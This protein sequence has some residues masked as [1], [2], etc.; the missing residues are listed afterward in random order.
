V[1][2]PRATT[3]RATP[4]ELPF[5]ARFTAR[6]RELAEQ[7]AG[8]VRELRRAAAARFDARGLPHSRIEQW[9]STNL[10]PLYATE[11]HPV[12]PEGEDASVELRASDRV[13]VGTLERAL[14]TIPE[15]L[16]PHLDRL[17]RE[18]ETAFAALNGA[19]LDAGAVVVIPEGLELDEPI[20]VQHTTSA[21]ARATASHPR[22]LVVAGR[23]SRARLVETYTGRADAVYFTNAVTEVIVADGAQLDH[24]RIQLESA[25]AFH[26]STTSSRQGRDSRYTTQAVDLGGRL[27]R[28]DVVARLDGPGA[29]CR[30]DGLVL[31]GGA[32]HVDNHTLLDHAQPH[33]DSRELYKAILDG[34]SRSVFN[35]RIIVRQGAQ[36]TDAK[37]SNPNLLLS[38]RALAQTRPQLEI[39]A[40]DVKCTHGATVG[41]LDEDALFYLT[42]RGI[43]RPAARGLLIRAFADEVLEGVSIPAVREALQQEVARRLLLPDER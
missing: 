18:H 15:E 14:R 41:R 6:E 11:F 37:Q 2:A 36:K 39:Y 25:A 42:S 26:V 27:V 8:W 40:D 1:S 21:T 30:L 7:G 16:R 4:R 19:L 20:H 43:P 10:S 12:G 34:G 31:I 29:A 3:E 5:L 24:C 35:G 32:Q 38:P 17:D 23:G 13:Y 9:R 22:T 28:H 33:C